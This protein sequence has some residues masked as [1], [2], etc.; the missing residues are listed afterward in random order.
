MGRQ[1]SGHGPGAALLYFFMGGVIGASVA[2]L[3][4]PKNRSRDPEDGQGFYE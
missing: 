1:D 4:T 2:L 3:A